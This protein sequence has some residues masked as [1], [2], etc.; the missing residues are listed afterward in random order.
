MDSRSRIRDRPTPAYPHIRYRTSH[1]PDCY[2]DI[3]GIP[4]AILER[5]IEAEERRSG[6]A[7]EG[8]LSSVRSEVGRILGLSPWSARQIKLLMRQKVFRHSFLIV[9]INIHRKVAKSAE[10]IFSLCFP[11]IINPGLF[12]GDTG[13]HKKLT[14]M[15]IRN[16]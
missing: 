1:V 16:G 10:F 14:P 6:Q 8:T 13:K 11:L 3:S 4:F 2:A 15:A 7:P 12:T 5:G 9:E